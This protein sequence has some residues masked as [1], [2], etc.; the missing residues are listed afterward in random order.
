MMGQVVS[1]SKLSLYLYFLNINKDDLISKT[2][3]ASFVDLSQIPF[4]F[5]YQ[6]GK[7]NM[8]ILIITYA[9]MTLTETINFIE[10]DTISCRKD[11]YDLWKRIY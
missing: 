3:L 11:G 4:V 8:V 5:C 7:N 1:D 2:E 10:G 6:K 9:S